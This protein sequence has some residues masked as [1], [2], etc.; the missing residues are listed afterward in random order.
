VTRSGRTCA[1]NVGGSVTRE[2]A[3]GSS[4][5]AAARGTPTATQLG[6]AAP[7]P[8]VIW[9][10]CVPSGVAGSRTSM[11][12]RPISTPFR[13]TIA[14]RSL[15][16]TTIAIGPSFAFSGSQ[17]STW[18]GPSRGATSSAPVVGSIGASIVG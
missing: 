15:P 18:S 9:N 7:P 12:A 17:R 3:M 2:A 11:R 10:A 8:S 6:L 4:G 5:I 16:L 14:R 13:S 1:T